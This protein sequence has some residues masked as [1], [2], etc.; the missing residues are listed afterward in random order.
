MTFSVG[1]EFTLKDF[2]YNMSIKPPTRTGK[3]RTLQPRQRVATI[4]NEWV[5][6]GFLERCD[7]RCGTCR[8]YSVVREVTHDD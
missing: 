6:M 2:A 3:P 4:L 5:R 7:V 8:Y 1:D